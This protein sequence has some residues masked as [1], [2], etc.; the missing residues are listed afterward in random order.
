MPLHKRESVREELIDSVYADQGLKAPP[1]V[2]AL[3]QRRDAADRRDAGDLRR[4]HARRQR[5]PEPRHVLPDLGGATGPSVDGPVHRQEP[6]RQGRVP[7]DGRARAALRPHAG[8]PV[9]RARER[10]AHRLLGHR[11]VRGLHAGRHGGQVALA[12]QAPGRWE[13]DRLAEHGVRAGPGRLAQIRPLLGR[14]DA[15]DPHVPGALPNGRRADARAGGREHHHGGPHLRGHLHRVL[16]AGARALPG[17]RQAP[18]GHR[19]RHRH[20][21]GRRQRGLPGPFLRTGRGMGLPRAAREVDQHLG[22]QVRPGAP[23]SGLGALAG[24]GGAA[25]RPDLPRHLPRRGHAG[26]PDQLLTARRPDRG[27]VLQLRAPRPRR[28][29]QHPR[30]LL[31]HGPVPGRGRCSSSARSSCCA[32]P[33]P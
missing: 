15:G 12:G 9:E 32:T 3:S 18:A 29:P 26:V 28:L 20:P 1:A 19:P 4:A 14:R 30:R 22:A 11:V 25:G 6:H 7:P 16:R 27:A 17:P 8:R 24:R 23:R 31:P 13:A 21:R 33:I 10:G 2:D 5:A